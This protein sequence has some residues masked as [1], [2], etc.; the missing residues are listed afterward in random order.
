VATLARWVRRGPP[1]D[2][3]KGA[4]RRPFSFQLSQSAAVAWPTIATAGPTAP[5][6]TLARTTGLVT[7]GARTRA[8]RATAGLASRSRAARLVA[9]GVEAAGVSVVGREARRVAG[10]AVGTRSTLALP[11]ATTTRATFAATLVSATTARACTAAGTSA[12]GLAIRLFRTTTIGVAMPAG[13]GLDAVGHVPS[14]ERGRVAIG[15]RLLALR[16]ALLERLLRLLGRGFATDGQA[17]VAL[18]AAATTATTVLADV[19]E[20]T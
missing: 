6:R 15:Q 2:K 17:A 4:R 11:L 5:R 20:A 13:A 9:V 18:R 14:A 7:A 8:T 3:K 16:R 19:V 1:C 10:V 12:T